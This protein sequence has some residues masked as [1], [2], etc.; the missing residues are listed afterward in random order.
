MLVT[1]YDQAMRCKPLG[2][3]FP[4]VCRHRG[5]ALRDRIDPTIVAIAT[6]MVLVTTVLFAAPL[7]FGRANRD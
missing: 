1:L 3:V 5:G 6:M 2:E 7:Y 4:R